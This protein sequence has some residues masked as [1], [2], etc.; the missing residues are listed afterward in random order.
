M[1]KWIKAHPDVVKSPCSN[2]TILFKG[3][4]GKKIPV[5]KLLLQCLY[6]KLHNDMIKSLAKGS[7]AG[8][9]N[10]SGKVIISD[11]ALRLNKPK[12]LKLITN[13]HKQMCSCSC[14]AC[15]VSK[16]LLLTLNKWRRRHIVRLENNSMQ[17]C[18]MYKQHLFL[19]KN[20]GIKSEMMSAMYEP[21]DGQT[22]PSWKCVIGS[23]KD[24]PEYKIPDKEKKQA[25]VH[26]IS[27]FVYIRQSTNVPFIIFF[28]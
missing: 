19:F 14:E 23:F 20:K 4:D 13:R 5:T 24:C 7:F 12:N 9:R 16:Q 22:L 17:R 25:W 10:S 3:V 2:D 6:V 27:Y 1:H 28:H 21:C 11:T 15:I 18:D 8:A 26:N